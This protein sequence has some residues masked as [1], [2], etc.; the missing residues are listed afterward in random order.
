MI[1]NVGPLKLLFLVLFAHLLVICR[2]SPLGG[3]S[4]TEGTIYS[5]II[6]LYYDYNKLANQSMILLIF[7]E[8]ASF[9]YYLLL[10]TMN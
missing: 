2:Q 10:F 8:L 1:L 6:S 4:L 9:Y 7:V 3:E 5:Y